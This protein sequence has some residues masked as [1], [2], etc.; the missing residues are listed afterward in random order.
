M[1]RVGLAF[2]RGL[3]ANGEARRRAHASVR[4]AAGSWWATIGG[5]RRG[6]C[7]RFARREDAVRAVDRHYDEQAWRLTVRCAAAK[8]DDTISTRERRP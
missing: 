4:P 5:E 8:A 1:R 3:G 7:W 2:K 6:V